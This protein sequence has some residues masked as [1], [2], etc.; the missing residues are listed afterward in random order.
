MQARMKLQVRRQI[1]CLACLYVEAVDDRGWRR[2]GVRGW[3]FPDEVKVLTRKSM[4][5]DLPI[6]AQRGMVDRIG[7]RQAHRKLPIWIYRISSRGVQALSQHCGAEPRPFQE[8]LDDDPDEDAVYIPV[9]SWR[10]VEILRAR[11]SNENSPRRFGAPG[12]MS[13]LEVRWESKTTLADDLWWLVQQGLAERRSAPI[14]ERTQRPGYFYRLTDAGLRAEFVD[15][16]SVGSEPPLRV[17]A[18]IGNPG[19]AS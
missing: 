4:S 11:A 10:V 5:E 2:R 18:R 3:R 16:V 1:V 8:A 15:A 7:I 6:L 19:P 12:W 9:A 17:Q 14:P 13:A